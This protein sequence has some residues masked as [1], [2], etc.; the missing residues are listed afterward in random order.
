M[1]KKRFLL[2][3]ITASL[4]GSSC[5]AISMEAAPEMGLFKK[6]KKKLSRKMKLLKNLLLIKGCLINNEQC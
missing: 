6:K 4:I 1:N 5:Y 2:G 3:A